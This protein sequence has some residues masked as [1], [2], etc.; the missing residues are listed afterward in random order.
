LDAVPMLAVSAAF[1][2]ILVT[3]FGVL[4]QALY[5]SGDMDFLLSAPVPIRAVFITKLL[6][7]ILPNFGLICAFV[8]PLLFGLG[9]AAGYNFLYYPMVLIVL[10]AL[11]LA[12]A[13]LASLMVMLVVRVFPARR[14]AEVLGFVGAIVAFVCSQSGQLVRFGQFS[15]SQAGQAIQMATR[16]NA[17]WSPLSWAGKGLVALGERQWLPAGGLLILSVGLAFLIFGI[18]LGTA[19]RL[20]YTGWASV[21]NNRRRKKAVQ[22]ARPV[23]EK[24]SGRLTRR[25]IPPAISAIMVKDYYVLRRDLRNLSQ[26]VTPLIFGIIY[27][28]LF[29]RGGGQPP[30]GQGEAPDSFNTIV[31]NMFVYINVGISLFVGWMLLS[32]LGGMGFSQE[33][34]NYWMLKAAP[35]SVAQLITAKFLVAYIPSLALGWVFLLVISLVQRAS[36]PLLLF[37]LPVVGLCIGGNAGLNLSF[38][39][40]GANMNWEDPRH[41]QRGAAGCVGALVSMIYMV[42]SLALFFGPVVILSLFKLP[43]SLGQLTGLLLGGIFCLACAVIPLWLASKRVPLLGESN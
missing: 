26:L 29:L 43:A 23:V 42:V 8:L 6:Q 35:L 2:G 21:Q 13:G 24:P 4:L 34:K 10:A 38:G 36:L 33:G 20:Y 40:V 31:T 18:A 17:P 41:M 15:E 1:L 39:I 25:F 30:L 16:F 11:A 37:T 22:T 28:V 27:A 5:L 7:A 12:A 19:E 9:A 3:S 14:V 32:R